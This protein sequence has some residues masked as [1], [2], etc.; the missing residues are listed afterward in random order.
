[1]AGQVVATRERS[2]P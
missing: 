1:M 2:I